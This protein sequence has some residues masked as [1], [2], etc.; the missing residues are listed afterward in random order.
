M[1]EFQDKADI[2]ALM[3][4]VK[5]LDFARIKQYADLFGEWGFIAELKS[6]L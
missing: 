3:A 6:R 2:Q 1:R 4:N 5:S